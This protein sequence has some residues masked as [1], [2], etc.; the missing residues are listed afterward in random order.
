MFF[1]AFAAGVISVG[2]S[3]LGIYH[4]LLQRNVPYI[5]YEEKKR[6]LKPGKPETFCYIHDESFVFVY[7]QPNNVHHAY[8]LHAF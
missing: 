7:K 3:S 4:A 8:F 2:V 1:R 5:E 6:E